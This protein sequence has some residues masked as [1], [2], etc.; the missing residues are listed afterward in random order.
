LHNL[1]SKGRISFPPGTAGYETT[2]NWASCIHF[3][4]PVSNNAIA[5]T[6]T[7]VAALLVPLIM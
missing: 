3:Q 4:F 2:E 5:N 7:K 6:Q 1:S